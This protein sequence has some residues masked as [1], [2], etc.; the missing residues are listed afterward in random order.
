MADS[1]TMTAPAE[2][3][4]GLAAENALNDKLTKAAMDKR[5]RSNADPATG[6]LSPSSRSQLLEMLRPKSTPADAV[7]S[8]RP[9]R[10]TREEGDQ[11]EV[12]PVL[13]ASLVPARFVGATFDNYQPQTDSQTAAVP[14]VRQW[15]DLAVRGAGPMLALIGEQG[16]GKSHLL[17]AAANALLAGRHK[18]YSRPWYRLAD[19]LRYGGESPFAPGKSMDAPE[20]RALLWKHRIVLLD[21]VRATASTAFDDTELAKF[22]CHAYDAEIAVLV[23]TNVTP[24]AAVMGP[25]A[26]SRFMQFVIDG[27]DWRQM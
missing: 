8:E 20:V 1:E 22:A 18:F 13:R 23:T 3:V 27:P 2:P 25:P 17:Y 14:A 11:P 16:A 19:E 15:V 9:A 26:A 5:A 4:N 21:E 12:S 10:V 6:R 7:M 24:L